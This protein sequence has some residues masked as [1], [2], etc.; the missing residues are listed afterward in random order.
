MVPVESPELGSSR[1]QTPTARLGLTLVLTNVAL[2]VLAGLAYSQFG[3]I[4]T[5]LA[6]LKGD[7]V[8]LYPR[9][10]SIGSLPQGE[11]KS[12]CTIIKNVA[13]R[14]I[15]IVGAKPSCDC[16]VASKLPLSLRPGASAPLDVLFQGSSR[17]GVISGNLI[18]FTDFPAQPEV[19]LRVVG[20]VYAV[21]VGAKQNTSRAGS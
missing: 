14:E 15:N 12:V 6:F 10:Q 16:V 5:A 9:V 21:D 2:A 4:G 18:L 13:D 1:R 3:S 11:P 7:R 19:V 8:L 17:T 20:K